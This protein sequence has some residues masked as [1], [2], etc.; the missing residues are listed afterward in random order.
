MDQHSTRSLTHV[1]PDFRNQNGYLEFCLDH[2]A[3]NLGKYKSISDIQNDLAKINVYPHMNMLEPVRNLS[4]LEEKN[5]SRQDYI[6]AWRNIVEGRVFTEHAAA[7]EAT[8][9]KL[10]T[11]YLINIPKNQSVKKIAD[12][13]SQEK[14]HHI[15]EEMVRKELFCDPADLLPICL[16]VRHMLQL[17]YDIIKLATL[18]GYSPKAVLS[19]QKML[20]I[21]NE[22][23]ADIIMDKFIRHQFYGF[24]YRNVM[25][26]IQKSFHGI[27]MNEKEVFYDKTSPLRLHNH[28]HIAISQT[29]P[30]Q[31]FYM[32]PHGGRRFLSDDEFAAIL[33]TT[34][35]KI[36]YNIEDLD[37]LTGAID[38]NTLAFAI[39]KGEQGYD[40]VME[41]LPNNPMA[42]QK[43]GMAAFDPILGKDVMIESFQL[44][45]IKNHQIKFLNKNVNYFP[46]PYTAWS[47]VKKH[48]L[49]LHPVVK[50]G[51]LYYQPV[52]GDINFL[53]KTA[54][55]IRK[56]ASPIKA[57]K[58]PA[59]T[60]AAI[61]CMRRQD[62]QKGFKELAG[63]FIHF[64]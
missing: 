39:Q 9:L 46:N 41:V 32:E 27:N 47:A 29:L 61:N 4:F 30:C 40:M 51:Y 62:L 58:S 60:P 49:K 36:S 53:V 59:T 35:I 55:F 16:G 14:G 20:V 3:E 42:P 37:Y 2:A 24:S 8:R 33:K 45:G 57:W 12:M 38:D 23:T 21:L 34:Q 15:T 11:K 26:M 5:I 17:S 64:Q 54:I 6:K 1:L 7:G 22:A 43:G 52:I 13:L 56:N 63:Q 10:S 50:D 19:K 44:D 28:G 48:G 31:I 18:M 25:F